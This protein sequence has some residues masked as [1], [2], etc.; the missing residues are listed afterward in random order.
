MG[1]TLPAAVWL[2]SR[3]G[4]DLASRALPGALPAAFL[5]HVCQVPGL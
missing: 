3:H 1:A 2:A 4:T 5:P